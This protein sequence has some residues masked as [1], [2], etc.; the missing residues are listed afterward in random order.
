M[1]PSPHTLRSFLH[2]ELGFV[3]K[4]FDNKDIVSCIIICDQK[5]LSVNLTQPRFM[6]RESLLRNCLV[7]TC[8]G[9]LSLLL[10]NR[11]RL[12]KHHFLGAGS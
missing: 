9:R 3:S 7:Q 12:S 8:V 4:S 10:L 6:L 2:Y 1:F 5:F 11:G